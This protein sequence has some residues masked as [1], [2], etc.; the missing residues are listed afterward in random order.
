MDKYIIYN[1]CEKPANFTIT[2]PVSN[3]HSFVI[4]SD[5]LPNWIEYKNYW[6]EQTLTYDGVDG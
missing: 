6:L 4:Y 1:D 2:T 3:K 5:N